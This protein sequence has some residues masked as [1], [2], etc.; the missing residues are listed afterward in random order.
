MALLKRGAFLWTGWGGWTLLAH[1]RLEFL[2][3]S[4]IVTVK[5][6][7]L[8]VSTDCNEPACRQRQGQTEVTIT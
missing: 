5:V 6:G 2:H 8:P 3:N 4:L 7:L 1:K